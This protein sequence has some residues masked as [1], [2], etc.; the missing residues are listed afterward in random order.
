MFRIL[1]AVVHGTLLL[2]LPNMLNSIS[3]INR[4]GCP[5]LMLICKPYR[6]TSRFKH[7]IN[8]NGIKRFLI[9]L[10]VKKVQHLPLY[11]LNY[12]VCAAFRPLVTSPSPS[13]GPWMDI[14]SSFY[15]SQLLCLQT[16]H[17]H[18]QGETAIQNG[19]F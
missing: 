8:R 17:E 3:F 4:W 14:A 11:C 10:E 1:F 16:E 18:S 12:S 13:L 9:H 2:S 15:C 19:K 7:Q 5:S 6:T